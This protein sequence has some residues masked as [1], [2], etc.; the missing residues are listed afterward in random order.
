MDKRLIGIDF[1]SNL[2]FKMTKN[3]AELFMLVIEVKDNIMTIEIQLAND[4]LVQFY[5]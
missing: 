2:W 4:S 1:V 5:T 3:I